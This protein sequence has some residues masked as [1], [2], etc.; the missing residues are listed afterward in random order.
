MHTGRQTSEGFWRERSTQ[1]NWLNKPKKTRK[2]CG[3]KHPDSQLRIK[4]LKNSNRALDGANSGRQREL[5]LFNF[6]SQCKTLYRYR[7]LVFVSKDIILMKVSLFQTFIVVS[8]IK[9][10]F[11]VQMII[12]FSSP[13][14]LEL[15]V[16]LAFTYETDRWFYFMLLLLYLFGSSDCTW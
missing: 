6:F 3:P 10:V 11:T 4:T 14:N 16:W 15:A 12:M 13:L 2:A 7:Y 5:T 9:D 8:L 1:P